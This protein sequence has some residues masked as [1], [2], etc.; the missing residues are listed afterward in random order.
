VDRDDSPSFDKVGGDEIVPLPPNA[1][2]HFS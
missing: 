2:P 1:L